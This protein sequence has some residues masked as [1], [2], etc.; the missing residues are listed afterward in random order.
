MAGGHRGE[1]WPMSLG[2]TL[3]RLP[4]TCPAAD[5]AYRSA[6]RD[7]VRALAADNDRS[8]GMALEAVARLHEHNRAARTALR[9][10]WAADRGTA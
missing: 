5:A 7:V 1:S 4:A 10:A 3:Q 2:R 6:Q 8:L 9:D